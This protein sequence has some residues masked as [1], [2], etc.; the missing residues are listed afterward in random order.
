MTSSIKRLL[1]NLIIFATFINLADCS[2]SPSI[3][4]T[5]IPLPIQ[6]R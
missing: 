4:P 5:K 1:L 2:E 3:S 6:S